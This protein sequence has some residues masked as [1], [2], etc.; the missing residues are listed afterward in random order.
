[1]SDNHTEIHPENQGNLVKYDDSY[2]EYYLLVRSHGDIE[3]R[4]RIYNCPW[5]GCC[6]PD[7]LRD[8]WFDE[9]EAMGIDPIEHPDMIP[10]AYKSDEWWMNNLGAI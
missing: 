7:S 5:C 4:Q 1:M 6:L 3:N 9:L 8:Q 10:E 2:R